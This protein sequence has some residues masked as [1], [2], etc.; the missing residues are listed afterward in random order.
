MQRRVFSVQLQVSWEAPLSSREMIS[1]SDQPFFKDETG[2]AMT[3]YSIL[4][5]WSMPVK[6]R[7][8]GESGG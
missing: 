4:C 8:K 5:V 2:I 3:S 1:I 6:S 7:K